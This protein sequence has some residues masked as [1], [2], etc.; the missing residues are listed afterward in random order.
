MSVVV[1]SR[2]L[3]ATTNAVVENAVGRS[4]IC[5][6][7]SL[8]PRMTGRCRVAVPGVVCTRFWVATSHFAATLNDPFNCECPG[9]HGWKLSLGTLGEEWKM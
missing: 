3:Q 7:I 9:L 6:W 8:G 1:A 4:M 5:F 2:S